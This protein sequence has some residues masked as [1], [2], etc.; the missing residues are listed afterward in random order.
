LFKGKLFG[1]T[2]YVNPKDHEEPIEQVLVKMTNGGV[3]HA[4]ECC[5]ISSCIVKIFKLPFCI[6][7]HRTSEFST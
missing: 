3:D 6:K 4:L 1:M 7:V 2:D 5:G